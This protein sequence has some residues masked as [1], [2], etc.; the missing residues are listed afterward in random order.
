MSIY[1]ENERPHAMATDC[2]VF[3]Y[4]I[5]VAQPFRA[6]LATPAVAKE[7]RDEPSTQLNTHICVMIDM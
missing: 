1:P 3:A 7:N 6:F 4:S 2:E 5:A